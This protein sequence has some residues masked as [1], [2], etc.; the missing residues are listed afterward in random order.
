M[1]TNTQP[2]Q[3]SGTPVGG[4]FAGKANPEPPDSLLEPDHPEYPPLK[5]SGRGRFVIAD[6]V[7]RQ[8]GTDHLDNGLAIRRT[9]ITPGGEP[10]LRARA[11]AAA[12]AATETMPD[13][14]AET[15][16]R[17]RDAKRVT[18]LLQQRYSKFVE[19]REGTVV[20]NSDGIGLLDK[21][22]RTK[23]SYIIGREA[24][25]HVLA[26]R[27]G[28][29]H[30]EEL[31]ASY[32]IAEELLPPVIPAGTFEDIPNVSHLSDEPPSDV[33]AVFILDHPGFDSDQDGRGCVFFATDRDP[34]DVVNGYFVAPPGSQLYSESGSFTTKQLT[35]ISGRVKD[36]RPGALTFKDAMDLGDRAEDAG[37]RFVYNSIPVTVG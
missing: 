27:D 1:S 2:R 19:V 3:P 10:D 13:F 7:T 17:E 37:M 26:V 11:G 16:L 6:T 28:Y 4:Q 34:E 35:T 20:V 5:E 30:A 9:Q 23:G 22:A 21:G 32:R 8:L 33:A 14:D 31:A 15:F 36:Y 12:V 18:I 24:C 25:P 29:G